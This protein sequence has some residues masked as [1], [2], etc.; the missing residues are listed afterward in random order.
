MIILGGYSVRRTS[1]SSVPLKEPEKCKQERDRYK[2]M[3]CE[4]GKTR[5]EVATQAGVPVYEAW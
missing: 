4:T 5:Q 2:N 1:A 3:Y